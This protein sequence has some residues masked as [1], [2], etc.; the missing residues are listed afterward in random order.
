MTTINDNGLSD[1]ILASPSDAQAQWSR[2]E[3]VRGFS[4]ELVAGLSDADASGQ[5]MPDASP[6]KWHL[7]HT[8]W[9]FET[10]VLRDFVPGYRLFD[11]AFAFLYNSYYEAE[12]DR[13]ARPFRGMLTRPSLDEVLEY[14]RH[15]DIAMMRVIDDLP[16]PAR[17]LLLLGCNHEEQHQELLLTDLL[18]LFAQNP[19]LPRAF[20]PNVGLIGCATDASRWIEGRRGPVEIGHDGR[21]FAFDCEGPRHMVWLAPH[22]L[23]DRLVTNREWRAFMD[24]D[25]YR[26]AHL[27][28]SDGWSWVRHN[29][30]EA[31]MYWCRDETGDWCRQFGLGGVV[32]LDP[33][34]PVQHVSYYEADAFARWAG[35]RLPTEAEW[36]SAADGALA[37]RGV[38]L[39]YPC[40]VRPTRARA[41]DGVR[42]LF[43]DLWEWT[44]SPFVAYAGFRPAPGAVGE[45]NG[46]F[47]SGQFVLR[48]GSC[49]TPRG[50]V[51]ASYRNFFY[52]HQ[53][54]QFT[55][56]RLAKDLSCLPMNTHW[57]CASSMP[58]RH[59]VAMC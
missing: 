48:G 34:C 4:S 10:F 14:R 26:T 13:L 42:Q 33:A 24:D 15:V 28:L 12:G 27:W 46:K 29:R 57:I 3:G 59:F 58:I 7:A 54:W 16:A 40:A 17:D 23:A 1:L 49:A 5:S 22:A 35:T 36:E 43:G 18:H 19:L 55:G 20:V 25:G 30:I 44:A 53:R 38:F 21:G 52:P 2:F 51:R 47:M 45:Y 6:S 9:F 8:T 37:T 11:P 39:D 50:H 41:G 56:V 32:S 31:P